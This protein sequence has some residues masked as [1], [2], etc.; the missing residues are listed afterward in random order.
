MKMDELVP[1][2]STHGGYDNILVRRNHGEIP[3]WSP[4]NTLLEIILM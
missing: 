1:T 3:F 2:C 4:G